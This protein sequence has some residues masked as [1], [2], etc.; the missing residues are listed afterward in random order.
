M[1][2]WLSSVV[3]TTAPAAARR[4]H[5]H[6]QRHPAPARE[7]L[8]YELM[9]PSRT[10]LLPDSGRQLRELR[11]AAH[12][13]ALP[14]VQLPVAK[15]VNSLVPR[16]EL[17]RSLARVQATGG[18]TTCMPAIGPCS[19]TAKCAVFSWR[20]LSGCSLHASA[21]GLLRHGPRGHNK[22]DQTG[23]RTPRT[24]LLD[25]R[26][27]TASSV[28]PV[29]PHASKKSRRYKTHVHWDLDS[30]RCWTAGRRRPAAGSRSAPPRAQGAPPAQVHV[31]TCTL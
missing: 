30:H 18:H 3:S 21:A 26:S 12:C 4:Q 7:V 19:L 15:F 1:M 9:C 23:P 10:R 25:G 17:F 27:V 6:Q 24:S 28:R 31:S 13:R 20:S 22:T 2:C 11:L 16:L 29:P 8:P 5:L 14:R